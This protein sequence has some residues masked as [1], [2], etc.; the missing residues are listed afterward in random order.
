MNGAPE[1]KK[2]DRVRVVLEGEV[3]FV[4]PGADW[5]LSGRSIVDPTH[6]HVVSVEVLPPPAT[7][8]KPGQVVRAR[9]CPECVFTIT[10][11]GWVDH[12]MGHTH[13]EWPPVDTFTSKD[14]E[15]VSEVPS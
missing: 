10:R 13:R 5:A 1:V 7:V 9:R 4:Y 11:T 14:Y 8:F 12:Q 2:G 3:T 15:L 6:D